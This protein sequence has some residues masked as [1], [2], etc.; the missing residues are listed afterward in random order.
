[1]KASSVSLGDGSGHIQLSGLTID[2]AGVELEVFML[3]ARQHVR[4]CHSQLEEAD[5]EVQSALPSHIS[6]LAC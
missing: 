1:V 6:L 4:L 5:G 2:R 3:T